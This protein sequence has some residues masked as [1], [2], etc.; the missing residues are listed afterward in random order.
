MSR[1]RFPASTLNPYPAGSAFA[2]E[3]EDRHPQAVTSPSKRSA[4]EAAYLDGRN[5]A[6]EIAE[7]CLRAGRPELAADFVARG[8]SATAVTKALLGETPSSSS[9]LDAALAHAKRRMSQ[10]EIDELWSKA[11]ARARGEPRP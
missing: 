6:R 8:M 1:H 2:A 4:W 9:S 10:G 11:I 7:L 5:E 3:W